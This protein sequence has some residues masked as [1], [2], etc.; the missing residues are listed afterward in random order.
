MNLIKLVN[1][2]KRYE[3]GNGRSFI[4]LKNINLTL[5]S[6]GFISIL[7]KSGCGKSTL[8]NI[9]GMMDEVSSGQYYFNSREVG[10]LSRLEKEDYR[11][12]KIGTIFQHYYLIEDQNVLFNVALPML[13]NGHKLKEA[14]EDAKT[15]LKGIGF[16][17]SLFEK[18]VSNL[19]GGEKQRVAI[20]RALIN[21]PNILIAD[22]PTG[23]L[24]SDNSFRIMEMLKKVSKKKLVIMVSHNEEIVRKYSDRII[25][26]KDGSIVNDELISEIDAINPLIDEHNKGKKNNWIEQIS[27]QNF[28]KR[29]KTHIFSIFALSIS[30]IATLLIGGFARYSEEAISKESKKKIDYGV[31][32]I[33]KEEKTELEGSFISLVQQSRPTTLEK[34]SKLTYF[35]LFL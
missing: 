23:A 9:I 14:I 17:E 33:S 29:V 34:E 30:L 16:D 7:G 21:N 12:T 5:P 6:A 32:T 13:I 28:K 10:K 2:S 20:L 15:L 35:R 26:L 4:A 3:L 1:V 27:L 19:S 24:D 25:T 11:A 31:L 8:L 18:K 22:E